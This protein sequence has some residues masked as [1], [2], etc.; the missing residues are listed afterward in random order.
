MSP[1]REL[2]KV[3]DE[4][5]KRTM[6]ANFDSALDARYAIA[7]GFL[8]GTFIHPLRALHA[9]QFISGIG[10]TVNLVKTF[11]STFTSGAMT[12]GGGDS[13]G[14]IEKKLLEDLQKKGLPI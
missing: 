13:R 3:T 7:K 5:L 6:Q 8:W 1:V 2:D 14:L 4:Q 9:R 10:Q 12:F 11:G